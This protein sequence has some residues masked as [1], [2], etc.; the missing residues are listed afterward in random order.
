MEII[1]NIVD[2]SKYGI[3]CPHEMTA[4]RIVVHNTANNASARNEINYM[5]SNEN[6]VSF[7]FAVDDREVIQGIPLNRNAW[8]A[9]DGAEGI[10][11][12]EG[13]A[14]EIC[15]S[16]DDAD[17][18]K[19]LLAEQRAAQLIA[20]LLK[21]RNW[22]VTKVTKHQDYSGKYCPHRTLDL[23]W[24][25]FVNLVKEK[26]N[27]EG[28][29]K[30]V[31]QEMTTLTLTKATVNGNQYRTRSSVMGSLVDSAYYAVVGQTYPLLEITEENQSDG[32]KWGKIV[33]NDKIVFIQMDMEYMYTT[34]VT[35]SAEEYEAVGQLYRKI[36]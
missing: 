31:K 19:F 22:D 13:I 28:E 5:I 12:R 11:N 18:E 24:E 26:M 27:E 4:T 7:H 1:Q 35:G 8:H 33:I 25:R 20:E 34:A 29:I 32:Y 21:E 2:A 30:M 10:G 15:Y 17:L 9:G 16:K 6:Q 23:G 3:K 36:K 14:I